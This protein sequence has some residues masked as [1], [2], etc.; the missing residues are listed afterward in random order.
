MK[1]YLGYICA[2]LA[3]IF[4]GMIG[5]FSVKIMESGLSPYAIAFYKCLI[6]FL[7]ITGWLIL[8]KQLTQWLSY[9]KRMWWQLLVAAFFGFFV[10]YFFETAAY[11][12]ENVTIVV[13]MLLGSAVITTFILTSILDRK[14]LSTYDIVSCICALLGLA[15]IFGVNVSSSE[16]YLGLFLA[17]VAGI[18]YGTFLTMSPRF[19][20][21]SGLLVVNGLMLFGMLYLFIPFAFEGLVF[22]QDMNTAALLIFLALLPTIG[23][24]LCTTKAL[25]LLKSE[26]VQLVELSE[27]VFSIVFS[28]VFLHQFITLWQVA[29]GFLL[30]ISIYVNFISTKHASAESTQ[31]RPAAG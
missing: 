18:G 15:L 31:D 23:G 1:Q 20:I 11:K 8:S 2:F 5:I 16:N 26:S 25:T 4:N 3:A 28:F 13:F 19:K 29:G 14:W 27:P 6:S 7:I 10:L 21:G 30:M 24:F 12:Y 17:L 9:I 22:I